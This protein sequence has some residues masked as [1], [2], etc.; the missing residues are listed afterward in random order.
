VREESAQLEKHQRAG[1]SGN[2]RDLEVI[3]HHLEAAIARDPPVA[4]L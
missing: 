3:K 4:I 1:P 2:Q